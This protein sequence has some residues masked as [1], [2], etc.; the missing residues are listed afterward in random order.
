MN[1]QHQIQGDTLE[2]V[3]DTWHH[4]GDVAS[5]AVWDAANRAKDRADE[6]LDAMRVSGGMTL[7]QFL[8]SAR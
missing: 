8:E 1:S 6:A 7:D 3:L 4:A 5:M 2:E